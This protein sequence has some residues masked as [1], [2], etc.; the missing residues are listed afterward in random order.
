MEVGKPIKEV[1]VNAVNDLGDGF[2]FPV[3][4]MHESFRSS[5][6]IPEDPTF[7][8]PLYPRSS[9]QLDTPF[10]TYGQFSSPQGKMLYAYGEEVMNGAL[11]AKLYPIITFNESTIGNVSIMDGFTMTINT[12]ALNEDKVLEGITKYVRLNNCKDVELE[13]TTLKVKKN[14]SIAFFRANDELYLLCAAKRGVSFSGLHSASKNN[15]RSGSQAGTPREQDLNDSIT[16][17][18]MTRKQSAPMNQIISN[19]KSSEQIVRY[20]Q[21][22]APASPTKVVPNAFLQKPIPSTIVP[23]VST[24]PVKVNPQRV[25]PHFQTQPSTKKNDNIKAIQRAP[26]TKP[27]PKM[28]A[29]QVAPKL[30][31]KDVLEILVRPKVSS[32]QVA[33]KKVAP[34]KSTPSIIQRM[35]KPPPVENRIV[36]KQMETTDNRLHH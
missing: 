32:K 22:V 33:S 17:I 26:P 15:S 34:K 1:K 29:K 36:S 19:Y 4:I 28:V 7:N 21:Q 5:F 35:V 13:G 9:T 11:E 27:V 18:P 25:I 6:V 14:T 20:D 30:M 3:K 8:A 16:L 10:Y 12:Q 31:V 23:N 2:D 24:L